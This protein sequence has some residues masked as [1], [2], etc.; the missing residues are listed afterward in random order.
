MLPTTKNS[1]GIL[2]DPRQGRHFLLKQVN[3]SR[4]TYR[5]AVRAR[6]WRGPGFVALALLLIPASLMAVDIHRLAFH[7]LQPFA[8]NARVGRYCAAHGESP[9]IA[10]RA[11]ASRLR[12]S[13]TAV[14]CPLCPNNMFSQPAFTLD[15]ALISHGDFVHFSAGPIAGSRAIALAP[16][17]RAHPRGPPLV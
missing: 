8:A 4:R 2:L 13:R 10:E 15:G 9:A 12:E 3:G 17:F 5:T 1:S 7:G 16:L 14:E 11:N 6:I